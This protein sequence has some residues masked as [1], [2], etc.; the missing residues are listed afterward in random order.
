MFI[1]VPASQ[2]SGYLQIVFLM[3]FFVC[4][5]QLIEVRY[6][7]K[8]VIVIELFDQDGLIGKP[9]ARFEQRGK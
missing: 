1:L 5:C 9:C 2:E 7:D 3:G 6:T 4:G 8:V